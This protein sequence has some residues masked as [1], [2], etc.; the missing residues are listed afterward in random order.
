MA[1]SKFAERIVGGRLRQHADRI[2]EKSIAAVL[3]DS[4]VERAL[5]GADFPGNVILVAVGKAA[6]RMAH[7]AHGKLG[8][9]ISG[10]NEITKYGHS[11]GPIGNLKMLEAVH[12]VPDENS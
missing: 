1:N 5:E 12:P 10:G 2:V 7:A 4:A 6:W 8:S 11:L 3:P 9:R